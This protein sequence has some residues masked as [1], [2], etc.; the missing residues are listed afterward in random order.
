MA[1]TRAARQELQDLLTQVGI[2][3]VLTDE[4]AHELPEIAMP[5]RGRL[6]TE[7]KSSTW[8]SLA[9]RTGTVEVEFLNGEVV[10]LAKR[11]GRQ[12]PINEQLMNICLEMSAN[13]D[14]PGRYA[15]SQLR[16]LLGLK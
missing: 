9:R 8:Q 7:A 2:R 14:V 4:V 13:R 12:A 15:P 6:D 11:L 3:W 5:L 1:I 16:Q 10:Q